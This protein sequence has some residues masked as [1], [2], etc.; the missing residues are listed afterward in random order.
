MKIGRDIVYLTKGST[1]EQRELFVNMVLEDEPFG[2]SES[3]IK[4]FIHDQD[5]SCIF[6]AGGEWDWTDYN[7]FKEAPNVYIKDMFITRFEYID[8]KGRNIVAYGN[9]SFQLQDGGR[10]LKVFKEK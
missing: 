10:T 8:E 5:E 3:A 6:F 9:F 2:W 1:E 7:P 4:D